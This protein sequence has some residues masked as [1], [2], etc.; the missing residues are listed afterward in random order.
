MP[1]L[2]STMGFVLAGVVILY[3]VKSEA[4][5]LLSNATSALFGAAF[6]AA[7]PDKKEN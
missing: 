2:W 6:G 4:F 5:P 7:N 3:P 1:L